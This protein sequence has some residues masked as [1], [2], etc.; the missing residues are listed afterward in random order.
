M[1][2]YGVPYRGSPTGVACFEHRKSTDTLTD[3]P[4]VSLTISL[5]TYHSIAIYGNTLLIGRFLQI[6]PDFSRFFQCHHCYCY[7]HCYCHCYCTALLLL[8]G[9]LQLPLLSWNALKPSSDYFSI[10]GAIQKP[11]PSHE[12]LRLF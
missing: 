6:L 4:T 2:P 5:T 3:T 8:S 1:P 9:H 7:R 10:A 12:S 11:V